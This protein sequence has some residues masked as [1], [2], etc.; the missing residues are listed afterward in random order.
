MNVSAKSAWISSNRVKNFNFTDEKTMVNDL[1]QE[2]AKLHSFI[3]YKQTQTDHSP[4]LGAAPVQ[5]LSLQTCCITVVTLIWEQYE[6]QHS[7]TIY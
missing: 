5:R 6:K 4:V 1:K 2:A 3:F 7:T